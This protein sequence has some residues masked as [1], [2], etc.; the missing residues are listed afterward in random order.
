[1]KIFADSSALIALFR[2]D[3][4]NHTQALELSNQLSGNTGIISPYIFAETVTI[5]SQKEG[6]QQSIDAGEVLKNQF[7][8]IKLNRKIEDLAWEIF[9][10]QKSKNISFVDCTTFALCKEGA[11]DK[12][13]TFD[14]DFQANRIPILE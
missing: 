11:F 13:F 7:I 1:M 14:S 10:K 9:K 8:C 2:K 3:D 12:A 4:P 5:L 6:K